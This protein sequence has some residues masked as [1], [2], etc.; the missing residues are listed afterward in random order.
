MARVHSKAARR[1]ETEESLKLIALPRPTACA[2]FVLA[3]FSLASGAARAEPTLVLAP[4]RAVYELKLLG[5]SGAKAPA[6]AHGRI[7][8]DFTG[9]ACEGYVQNFRQITELQP[10]EGAPRV[11]DMRSA[12][13]EAGDG[14]EYR[15]QITTRVDGGDD[16]IDGDAR[17]AQN[18]KFSVELT[19]PTR[20]RLDL[21]GP[22]LFPTEHIKH[23]L[24]SARAP[25]TVLEARV[26]DGSGD[27]SKVFETTT[28]IG[29]PVTT[30]AQE[31][32]AQIDALK[33][34]RRWPVTISYFEADKRDGEPAY[35]LSFDLYE[36]GISRALKLDYGD[37]VLGG[38]MTELKLLPV[39]KCDK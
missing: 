17:K 32:P 22:V 21:P 23:I 26:Y 31:K 18:Q 35:V 10:E 8:F 12:T 16:D 27:G 19:K 24:A 36:N 39:P 11:S 20:G 14:H 34:M 13:F 7:A 9:S 15:F 1:G 2:A 25:E 30:A 6:Q 33:N 3:A 29:K 4:H 5:G 28:I 38:E 37:F